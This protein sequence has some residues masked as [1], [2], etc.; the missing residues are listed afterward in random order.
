M[1]NIILNCEKTTNDKNIIFDYVFEHRTRHYIF[2]LICKYNDHYNDKKKTQLKNPVLKKEGLYLFVNDD[3]EII[4]VG[5]S[6]DREL[7]ERV[8]QHFNDGDTGG[9]RKKLS[10][11]Q[12]HELEH[13]TLYACGLYEGLDDKKLD[14]NLK[15]ECIRDIK[16]SESLLIGTLRPKYNY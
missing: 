4:Y 3:G 12:L 8:R 10:P 16:L 1:N 6:H 5:S 2:E 15:C 14:E 13:S 7:M 11:E 9:L